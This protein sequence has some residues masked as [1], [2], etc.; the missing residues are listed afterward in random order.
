MKIN[1]TKAKLIISSIVVV[2]AVSAFFLPSFFSVSSTAKT[3]VLSKYELNGLSVKEMVN[4]LDSVTDEKN[5][6]NASITSTTLI[7]Y[8]NEKQYEFKLPKDEFYVSFAPYL[9]EIHPCQTHNLV[10]CKGEL[11]NKEFE[12]SVV[13]KDGTVILDQKVKSMNSGFIGLWL[14][15]D[16]EATLTINYKGTSVSKPLTTFDK[17]DTCITTPLKLS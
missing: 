16:I 6:L 12:I 4:K 2:V 8:D 1:T 9:N 7:L 17:S 3:R 13:K 10:S 11:F 5:G 15:R 14:P